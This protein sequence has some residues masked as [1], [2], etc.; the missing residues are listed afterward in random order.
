MLNGIFLD[1]IKVYILSIFHI[2]EVIYFSLNQIYYKYT[3][4]FLPLTEYCRLKNEFYYV[5]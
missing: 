1:C 4:I 5:P 2:R 3:D